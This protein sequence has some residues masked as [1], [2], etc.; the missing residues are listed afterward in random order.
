MH[1]MRLLPLVLLYVGSRSEVCES[2]PGQGAALLQQKSIKELFYTSA[3]LQE[4]HDDKKN[5]VKDALP[6]DL[7]QQNSSGFGNTGMITHL[8]CGVEMKLNA[9]FSLDASCSAAC[10]LLAD[11]TSKSKKSFASA[12]VWLRTSVHISMLRLRGT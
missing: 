3:P 8:P 10:P 7:L 11:P 1:V 4:E 5:P 9:S 2:R 6:E 12:S